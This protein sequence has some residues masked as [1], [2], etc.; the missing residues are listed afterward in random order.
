[1]QQLRALHWNTDR[2]FGFK[3]GSLVVIFFD[4]GAKGLK[5]KWMNGRSEIV[6]QS[7]EGIPALCFPHVCT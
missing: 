1:M 2:M 6:D 4:M 7:E 3:R 5:M